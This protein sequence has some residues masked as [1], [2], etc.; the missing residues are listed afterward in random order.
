[1]DEQVDAVLALALRALR[2]AA[3]DPRFRSAGGVRQTYPD[4]WPQ[5]GWRRFE[6]RFY[7]MSHRTVGA[8][9]RA[10]FG[11]QRF[12]PFDQ[13]MQGSVLVACN[14]IAA[15][16]PPL[17]GTSLPFQVSFIAKEE[18]FRVPVLG[19]SIRHLQAIPIRRGT[20]D[21]ECL[22]RAIELLRQGTS[23]LM[24]PEGTRQTPGRLGPPRWGFGYVARAAQRPILPVFL[25]GSRSWK[26][27]FLRHSPLEVWLGEALDVSRVEGHNDKDTYR[28]IGHQVMHRIEGLMLRSAGRRPL[29]GLHLPELPDTERL[30]ASAHS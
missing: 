27:R 10:W 17:V 6:S 20:A 19:A 23:V 7:R 25:R 15:L 11:V 4:A 14:H 5:D 1:L 12:G 28:R 2:D 21:Y 16:D 9:L 8:A 24:F 29:P 26:P 18:L 3:D 30:E 13:P 22:D